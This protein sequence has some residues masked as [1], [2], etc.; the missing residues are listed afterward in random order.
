MAL[1]LLGIP[2]IVFNTNACV[3]WLTDDN[4]P[5]F[6]NKNYYVVRNAGYARSRYTLKS[7]LF[8]INELI[9]EV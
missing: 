8:L 2:F 9:N 1:W 5:V 6:S 7:S 3:V 4:S